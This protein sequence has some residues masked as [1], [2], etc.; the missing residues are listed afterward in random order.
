MEQFSNE[1]PKGISSF[2]LAEM[3][4]KQRDALTFNADDDLFEERV[5]LDL[6]RAWEKHLTENRKEAFQPDQDLYKNMLDAI[7]Q[8]LRCIEN[9]R[10]AVIPAGAQDNASTPEL[11]AV[12]DSVHAL[13]EAAKSKS[14]DEGFKEGQLFTIFCRD[15][16]F[17]GD[18]VGNADKK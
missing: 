18:A 13:V 3:L 2:D 1:I 7:L 16:K 12:R 10:K 14:Y 15:Y 8:N 6:N 4:L 5:E 17:S 9:L 11:E